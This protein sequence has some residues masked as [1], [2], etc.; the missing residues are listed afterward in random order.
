MWRS[1]SESSSSSS[2]R[3]IPTKRATMLP[4]VVFVARGVRVGRRLLPGG[5]RHCVRDVCL[6]RTRTSR[7]RSPAR[8]PQQQQAETTTPPTTS[9]LRRRVRGLRLRVDGVGAYVPRWSDDARGVLR[10]GLG[11]VPALGL[12]LRPRRR[13]A[14]RTPRDGRRRLRPRVPLLLRRPHLRQARLR[15]RRRPPVPR[16][17]RPPHRRRRPRGE[18]GR[19]G[20]E[21]RRQLGLPASLRPHLPLEVR[22]GGHGGL[23]GL[24]S[25]W[26][27]RRRRW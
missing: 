7:R 27:P 9:P 4:V 11:L 16:L 24:P 22:T 17:L 26:F 2:R 21:P 12:D 10:R 18:W 25:G 23:S 5:A 6:R 13:P 15:R 8:G 1:S 20:P 14:Q 19:R 3:G